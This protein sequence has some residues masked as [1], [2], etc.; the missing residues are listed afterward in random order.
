MDF[1]NR[2]V[3]NHHVT[4][5][6]AIQQMY[7]GQDE[8]YIGEFIDPDTQQ[9]VYY[10]INIDGHGHDHCIQKLRQTDLVPFLMKPKPIESIAQFLEDSR[11]IPFFISSGAVVSLALIYPDRIVLHNCGDSQSIVYANDKRIY[12]NIPHDAERE[13][14]AERVKTNTD[15]IGLEASRNIKLL[16]PTQMTPRPS[17]Y[18]VYRGGRKLA[19]TRAIGHTNMLFHDA[20]VHEIALDPQTTYRV[21]L[22]SDGA[23]DMALIDNEADHNILT[24]GDA[25]DIVGFYVTRWLQEWQYMENET[26]TEPKYIFQYEA[27]DC[28]DVSACVIDIVPCLA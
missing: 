16:S 17:T 24:T 15:Y 1:V 19:P 5:S 14:E 26:D 21:V 7:K 18:V 8:N 25:T 10:A 13:D 23:F 9:R 27:K 11:A 12:I 4:L 22:C 3:S 20:E 6:K 28:D 2:P